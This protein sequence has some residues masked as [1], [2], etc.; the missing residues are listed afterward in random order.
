MKKYRIREYSAIWWIGGIVGTMLT[1]GLF[2]AFM[3]F[4]LCL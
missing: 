4:G 2:Y 1:L 3:V